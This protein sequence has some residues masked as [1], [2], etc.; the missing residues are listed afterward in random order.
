MNS[1]NL[2]R[3]PAFARAIRPAVGSGRGRAYRR[4]IGSHNEMGSTAHENEA[5]APRRPERG[6]ARALPI[7]LRALHLPSLS[8]KAACFAPEGAT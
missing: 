4:G 8:I 1:R 6:S 7:V 5:S 3:C 2:T